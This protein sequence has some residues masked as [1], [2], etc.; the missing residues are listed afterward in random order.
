LLYSSQLTLFPVLY[1]T[2]KINKFSVGLS[3]F[4]MVFT[5]GCVTSKQIKTINGIPNKVIVANKHGA[6]AYKDSDLKT[7]T[8]TLKQ[9]DVLFVVEVSDKAYEVTSEIS[10]ELKTFFIQKTDEI[11]EWNTYFALPSK[12]SPHNSNRERVKFYKTIDDLKKHNDKNLSMIEKAKHSGKSLPTANPVAVL[13]DFGGEVYYVSS[14][15]DNLVD[16]QYVFMGE[17]RNGYVKQSKN[18]S[19]LCRYISKDEIKTQLQKVKDAQISVLKNTS[20]PEELNSAYKDLSEL[21]G[22]G[23]SKFAAGTKT[24]LEIFNGP[25]GNVPKTAKQGIF[26]NES[27]EGRNNPNLRKDLISAYNKMVDFASI[28]K[29]WNENNFSCIP[30]EWI[31]D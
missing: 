2:M 9:W 6:K 14:L 15:V 21:I 24:I 13:Q 29:N 26:S 23:G 4:L 18:A 5:S 11:I 19:F 20:N 30:A 28:D 12:N 7:N 16:G 17:Y 22:K 27:I 31:K 8:A 3:F 25:N 1:P 10:N